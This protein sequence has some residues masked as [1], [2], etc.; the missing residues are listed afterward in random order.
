M[1]KFWRRFKEEKDKRERAARAKMN[2][3]LLHSLEELVQR[4]GHAGVDDYIQMLKDI[5]KG[6]GWEELPRQVIQQH[7]TLYHDAVKERQLLDR[8]SS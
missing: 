1:K 7:V 4:K 3:Q 2:A 5:H 6:M 8:G